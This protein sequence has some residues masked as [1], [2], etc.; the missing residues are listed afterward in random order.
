MP[1]SGLLQVPWQGCTWDRGAPR[2]QEG[3]WGLGLAPW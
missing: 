2:A 3:Q 1:T